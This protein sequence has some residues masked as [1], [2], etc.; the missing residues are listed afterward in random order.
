M[1]VNPTF[2]MLMTKESTFIPEGRPM[3][4]VWKLHNRYDNPRY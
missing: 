3:D 2:I 4:T 1:A